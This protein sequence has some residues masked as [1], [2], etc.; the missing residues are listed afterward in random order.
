M[1]LLNRN[2]QFIIFFMNR[3]NLDNLKYIGQNSCRERDD[4]YISVS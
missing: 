2:I 4:G 3:G 1:F